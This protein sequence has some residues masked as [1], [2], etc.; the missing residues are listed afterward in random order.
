MGL[1]EAQ[2]DISGVAFWKGNT[3]PP[4][5]KCLSDKKGQ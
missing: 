1:L 2:L 5:K 4:W 3:I